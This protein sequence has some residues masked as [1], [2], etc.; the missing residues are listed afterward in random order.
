MKSREAS[1][2]LERVR[3][4]HPAEN[5]QGLG[6]F[7]LRQKAY[8]EV[9]LDHVCKPRRQ[10]PA[11]A[12]RGCHGFPRKLFGFGEI[13]RQHRDRERIQQLDLSGRHRQFGLTRQLARFLEPGPRLGMFL[14][15]DLGPAE[16]KQ[17]VD[18]VGGRLLQRLAQFDSGP[19]MRKRAGDIADLAIGAR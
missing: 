12:P 18:P 14:Q 17:R 19:Q 5:L 10:L 6:E 1:P 11:E 13:L 16:G 7:F 4:F 8:G 15:G 2:K 3:P 9:L